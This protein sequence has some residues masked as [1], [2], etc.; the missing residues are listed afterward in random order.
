MQV[1]SS[2]SWYDYGEIDLTCSSDEECMTVAEENAS[3]NRSVESKQGC[4]DI[5]LWSMSTSMAV[6]KHPVMVLQ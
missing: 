5:V 6:T 1:T 2:S 4:E 3:A